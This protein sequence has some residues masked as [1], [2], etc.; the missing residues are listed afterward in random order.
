[1]LQF[2]WVRIIKIIQIVSVVA[3]LIVALGFGSGRPSSFYIIIFVAAIVLSAAPSLIIS[4]KHLFCPHCGSKS[5][6]NKSYIYIKKKDVFEC[7]KCGE[8][9][10]FDE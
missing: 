2:K 6:F 4:D 1:M 9:I 8:E 7:P 5:V 10:K 3:A